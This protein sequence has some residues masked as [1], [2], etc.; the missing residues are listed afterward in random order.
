MS[1]FDLNLP[2]LDDPPVEENTTP[3][4]V[5]E[6]REVCGGGALAVPVRFYLQPTEEELIGFYLFNKVAGKDDVST[7]II[8][9]CDLYG[10]KYPWVI[11]HEFLED[12]NCK[13]F[14]IDNEELHL[15]TSLNKKDHSGLRMDCRVGLGTWVAEGV[16]RPVLSV[17]EEGELV[18]GSK[19]RYRFEKRGSEHHHTWI[20]MEYSLDDS[21]LQ[22]ISNPNKHFVLCKIKKNERTVR[23]GT[24]EKKPLELKDADAAK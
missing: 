21:L 7:A 14:S 24:G 23:I 3:F 12:S 16:R 2:P 22:Q 17:T 11:W 5:K 1:S 8:P 18:V 15:F 19:K 9:E 4:E 13:A 20:M 10:T 6:C